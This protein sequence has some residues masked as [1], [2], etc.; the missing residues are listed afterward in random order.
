MEGPIFH[1]H[2]YGRK[3]TWVFPK[4]VIPQNG[5]FT[6]ENPIKMDDLGGPPLFLETPTS[7]Q[8]RIHQTST[9]NRRNNGGWLLKTKTRPASLRFILAMK[10][11][12]SGLNLDPEIQKVH[13][14]G[15]FFQAENGP[16]NFTCLLGKKKSLP[17]NDGKY[18][19]FL[20]GAHQNT[21]F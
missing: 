18:Q 13:W 16:K 8:K 21:T 12:F 15:L 19:W 1:V 4:I 5:W 20:V 7:Q 14:F 11:S 2:D 17:R 9:R 10:A 3:G 6:R